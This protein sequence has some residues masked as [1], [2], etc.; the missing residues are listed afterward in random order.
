MKISP[1]TN[2]INRSH[3]KATTQ[4]TNTVVTVPEK[5]ISKEQKIAIIGALGVAVVGLYALKNRG[6]KN[7]TLI[8]NIYIK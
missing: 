2:T 7:I 1:V 8:Q 5:R 4:Q 6:I 3:F